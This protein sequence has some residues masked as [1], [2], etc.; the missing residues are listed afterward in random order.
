MASIVIYAGST[1]AADIRVNMGGSRYTDSLG[2]AWSAD[3]GFNTGKVSSRKV[4][5]LD[6]TDD[7]LYHQQR[8]DAG[9]APELLYKFT[10]PNGDYAVNL[11]FAETFSGTFGSGLRVFDVAIEGA[12]VLDNVDIFSQAGGAN[13]PLTRNV[14][15][16]TVTDGQ[17]NIEFI[18]QV[19]NPIVAAIEIVALGLSSDGPA[20]PPT[21]SPKLNIDNAIFHINHNN[22]P[23]GHVVT[24]NNIT[25]WFLANRYKAGISNG[26]AIDIVSDPSGDPARGNVMRVF[27][28]EG[29]FGLSDGLHGYSGG[30]WRSWPGKH[31]ELYFAFDIYMEPG[32][33]WSK[34][35]KLPG[36]VGGDWA[37]ADGTHGFSTRSMLVSSRAY[38]NKPD[39][40]L[41]EY[42]YYVGKKQG[43]RWANQGPEG[44]ITLEP[45]QWYTIET[46]VKLNT[47]DRDDG[48]LKMWVDGIKVLGVSN[49]R[50]RAV[51]SL[52]LDGLYFT[53]GYGGG[54]KSF[55]APEDQYNYYDNWI[56]STQPISH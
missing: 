32:R 39:G 22:I 26:G 34:I 21:V 55:A 5:I 45:G 8:W 6:T 28:S 49:R 51:N 17:M 11:H 35:M 43:V 53:F 16:V 33:L 30:Q 37:N 25:N 29:S 54:D 46:Y 48:Q 41:T 9:T 15:L 4:G 23:A 47:P 14:P 24:H 18:H 27:Q 50:W 44:Q 10:V 2:N 40:T 3:S 13:R 36:F 52:K 12:L 31:D 1:A 42:S 19:Q 56:L 20:P 7:P 38:P